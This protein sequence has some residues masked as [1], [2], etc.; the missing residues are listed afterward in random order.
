[1]TFS[2]R[3]GAFIVYFSFYRVGAQQDPFSIG[4]AKQA[5]VDDPGGILL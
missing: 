4:L 3:F 2:C 5:R 1:M